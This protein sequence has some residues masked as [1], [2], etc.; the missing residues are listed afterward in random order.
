MVRRI[1]LL[2]L[3]ALLITGVSLRANPAPTALFSDPVMVHS[4]YGLISPE[5]RRGKISSNL[6]ITP[7]YQS[8]PLNKGAWDHSG[9][10]GPIADRFGHWN[11]LALM[12]GTNAAPCDRPFEAENYPILFDATQKLKELGDGAGVAC[13]D[14]TLEDQFDEDD[15]KTGHY[16]VLLDYEKVGVRFGLEFT[17]GTGFG[18]QIKNGDSE[19]TQNPKS[20]QNLTC[21]VTE[22]C[23][24]PLPT[25]DV[26]DVEVGGICDVPVPVSCID[27][28]AIDRH[29][30]D[31]AIRRRIAR[32]LCFANDFECHN[33]TE[34]ED[35][36][37]QLHW[38]YPIRMHDYDGLHTVNF[39]PFFA[40]GAWLP[41]GR[42]K[43]Q[44]ILFSL[45]TGNDEFLGL[46]FDVALNFEF[47]DHA[48]ERDESM[49]QF[50]VGASAT[51]FESRDE[52][53]FRVPSSVHQVGII[54]WKT[55]V[56]RR[57]GTSWNLYSTL[58]APFFLDHLT[59]YGHYSYTRHERDTI[60][61]CEEKP[62]RV[63]FFHPEIL[64]EE[65]TWRAQAV[66]AGLH[67]MAA[68][69]LGFGASFQT[70]FEGRRVYRAVT[71]MGQV[72]F[73]F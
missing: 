53:D 9:K 51:F 19:Y 31:P 70:L 2:V 22:N 33:T 56:R 44:D 32:E 10:R 14:Y 46:T 26:C 48:H 63:E 54:P 65:S 43:T 47:R 60:K 66:H 13:R 27:V 23:P 36:H 67:Y 17:T 4:V 24:T 6:H 15:D 35:T 45:P 34:F 16:S 61:I 73:V 25:L 38:T 28:K 37:V 1:S 41:T 59:F 64:E 52:E 7:F 58:K 29:L 30:M 18:F 20:F 8:A 71:M 39:I 12:F 5:V 68:K 62:E 55:N 72:T 50:G 49:A 21:T 42:G 69:N 11:M 57:L 40:L 3:S